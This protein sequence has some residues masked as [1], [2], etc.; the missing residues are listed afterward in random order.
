MQTHGRLL[1]AIAEEGSIHGGKT[2]AMIEI[3][4]DRQVLDF[5][6]RMDG[7]TGGAEKAIFLV[8]CFLAE[9]VSKSRA[10]QQNCQHKGVTHI[11]F[12]HCYWPLS[13]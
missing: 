6:V 8:E 1:Y 3:E 9:K 5:V 12:F 2:I 13:L 10:D 4:I 11:Y 7:K